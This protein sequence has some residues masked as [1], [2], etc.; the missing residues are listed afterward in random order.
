M[1]KEAHFTPEKML[2][3]LGVKPGS[4]APIALIPGPPPRTLYEADDQTW[5]H[6]HY[7]T[8]LQLRPW[9]KAHD[10]HLVASVS[11]PQTV[12]QGFVMAFAELVKDF[13]QYLK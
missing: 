2:S 5:V 4:L 11:Y 13:A 12:D 10:C 7:F 8:E 1:Q 3:L 9:S 6:H